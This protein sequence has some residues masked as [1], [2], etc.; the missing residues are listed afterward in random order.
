MKKNNNIIVLMA[1][2]ALSLF[3]CAKENME[4]EKE[5]KFVDVVFSV[6]AEKNATT[7]PTTKTELSDNGKAVNWSDGDKVAVFDNIGGLVNQA[8]EIEKENDVYKLHAQVREG[9]SSFYSLYPYDANA[10]IS[11]SVIKTTLPQIQ[12]AVAGSFGPGA[13][14]SV[15]FAGTGDASLTYKNISALIKFT[16]DDENVVS[17]MLLG[18]NN[19]KIAGQVSIDYNE[20]EPT[21]EASAVSVTVKNNDGTAL[22]NGATYYFA[23]APVT[24]S[25][26]FTLVL[27]KADGT[28]AYRAVKKSVSFARK[29]IVD[30]GTLSS[31]VYDG[32]LYAAFMAGA[33]IEIAGKTYNKKD[34]SASGEIMTIDSGTETNLYNS[35]GWNKRRIAFLSGSAN[36]TFNG[37][38]QWNI[39]AETVLVSRY[40]SSPV[41]IKPDKHAS[42]RATA[43]VMKNINLDGTALSSSYVCNNAGATANFSLHFDD[44]TLTLPKSVYYYSVA[45]K[46]IASVRFVGCNIKITSASINVISAAYST[47]MDAYKEFVFKNNVVYSESLCNAHILNYNNDTAQ[48]NAEDSSAWNGAISAKN[49]IFYNVTSTNGLFRQYQVASLE[50]G[51]NI[52]YSPAST[53]NS[54]TYYLFSENQSNDAVTNTGDVVFGLSG[55]NWSYAGNSYGRPSGVTNQLTNEA[56]NPIASFD[57]STGAYTLAAGYESYGPQL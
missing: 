27:T 25:N 3:S 33:S 29:N 47:C 13:N 6:S 54:K 53:G 38:N 7:A 20:G 23:I 24:F 50:V 30:F 45:D 49:N 19:E 5:Y 18:N 40:P 26:G 36:F 4:T 42:I 56:T 10:S 39:L 2:A 31:M 46:G 12:Q 21:V 34:F 14:L 28:F 35:I 43:L 22:T 41:T 16:L 37:S 44:C 32:D 11:G 57:T 15:A 52:Y 8:F 48:T 51:G 1:V 9:S 17:A 55:A